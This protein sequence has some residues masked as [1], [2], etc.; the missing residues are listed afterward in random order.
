LENHLVE[1]TSLVMI[2]ILTGL[3][4][5]RNLLGLDG[6]DQMTLIL[7]TVLML[8]AFAPDSPLVSLTCLG[9]AT[10]Q[11]ALAYATAG[12]SKIIARQWR[13]G[14]ALTGIMNTTA[15]GSKH[16]AKVLFR[17][18]PLAVVISWTI[19]AFEISFPAAFLLGNYCWIFLA[20]GVAFHAV[21]A[22]IMGLNNFF[23]AF[24]ATYPLIYFASVQLAT[25]WTR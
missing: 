24:V 16:L 17:C 14:M 9:F 15:Y 23:W 6:S 18:S 2:F 22:C 12:W 21:T 4:H 7:C 1:L 8:R 13:S 11:A 20:G 19:I 25:C 3:F 5:F 10:L